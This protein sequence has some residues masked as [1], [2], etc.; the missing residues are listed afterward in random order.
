MF[1]YPFLSLFISCC[2][3][4]IVSIICDF[5]CKLTSLES[6][7]F[8]KDFIT[9]IILIKYAPYFYLRLQIQSFHY[10]LTINHSLRF[11]RASILT[12]KT[13]F[14]QRC[15]KLTVVSH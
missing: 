9:I 3:H 11:P 7:F 13:F 8:N 6:D 4:Q 12:I 14:P 2:R 10:Y 15:K 1:D 5:A